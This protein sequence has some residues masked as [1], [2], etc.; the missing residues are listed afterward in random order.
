MKTLCIT[1]LCALFVGQ[2]YSVETIESPDTNVEN[3][4]KYTLINNGTE[5]SVSRTE[6]IAGAVVIPTIWKGKKVTA[7]A[8]DAFSYCIQ[9]ASVSIPNSI[10]SIGYGAFGNC[11]QL[12]NVTIPASVTNLGLFTFAG[13]SRLAT[14]VFLSRIPPVAKGQIFALTPAKVYVPAGTVDAYRAATGWADSY[15]K[16]VSQ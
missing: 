5:Y 7:I 9:M 8:D 4:W 11:T 10:T 2:V 14:V 6:R 12:N 15:D 1:L 3:G 13:C 16:I